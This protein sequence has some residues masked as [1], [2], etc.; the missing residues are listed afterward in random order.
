M[1]VSLAAA[2]L[3]GAHLWLWIT[4]GQ[5]VRWAGGGSERSVA[6]GHARAAMLA[7]AVNRAA[8]MLC[9]RASCLDRG[10]ALVV[11]LAAHRLPSRLVIG[12]TRAGGAVQFHAW[13]ECDGRVVI[14]GEASDRFL[15]LL[16][17]TTSSS[18]T[19]RA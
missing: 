1:R 3:A 19:C 13:V 5:A 12:A 11:L 6:A 14:G 2:A 8:A 4:P 15:P 10:L 16:R 18:A 9:C 17:T 7:S